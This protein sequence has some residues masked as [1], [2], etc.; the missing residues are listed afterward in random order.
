MKSALTFDDRK[1]AGI[2]L[3]KYLAQT[4]KADPTSW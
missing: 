4:Y 1:Q 3:G 2:L